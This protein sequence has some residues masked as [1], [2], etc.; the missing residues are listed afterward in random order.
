MVKGWEGYQK[1]N[2][3]TLLTGL[4]QPTPLVLLHTAP[5]RGVLDTTKP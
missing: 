4:T 3:V 5:K 1:S 2:N